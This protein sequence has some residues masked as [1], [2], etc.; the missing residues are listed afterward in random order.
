MKNEKEIQAKIDEL[1]KAVDAL[2]N[3][4]IKTKDAKVRESY[5]QTRKDVQQ[6]IRT[7]EWVLS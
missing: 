4:L 2:E 5:M 3:L 1:Q 7:L 6:D